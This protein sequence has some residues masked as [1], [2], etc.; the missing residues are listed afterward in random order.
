MVQM[1]FKLYDTYG[2][3]IELTEELA[4]QEGITVDMATFETEMEQQR[5][6]AREARQSSQSMQVQSDVLKI[7]ILKVNLLD[8]KQQNIKQF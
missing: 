1:R 6:R 2:F 5:T 8:M 4:S 7:L 3:P